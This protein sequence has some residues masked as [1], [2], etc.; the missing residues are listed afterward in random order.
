[1]KSWFVGH[2]ITDQQAIQEDFVAYCI[3]IFKIMK[4]LND[5]LNK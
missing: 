4:P 3:K 5:F 2:S 1:M